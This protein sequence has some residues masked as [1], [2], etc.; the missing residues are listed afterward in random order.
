VYFQVV[1]ISKKKSSA[2]MDDKG[3]KIYVP[4]TTFQKAFNSMNMVHWFSISAKTG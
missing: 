2:E 1:G 4:F 3:T